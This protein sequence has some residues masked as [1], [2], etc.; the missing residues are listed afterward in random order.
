MY[1]SLEEFNSHFENEDDY[2]SN[3]LVEE[4]TDVLK[5]KY[6]SPSDFDF[7][8]KSDRTFE[9]KDVFT[10]ILSSTLFISLVCVVVV[11]F[12]KQKNRKRRR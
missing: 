5:Y 1:F 3:L 9:L 12:S 7:E 6:Y 8:E 10:I 11:I 4:G 2:L